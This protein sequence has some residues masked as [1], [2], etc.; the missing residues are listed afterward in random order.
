MV[1][2]STRHGGASAGTCQKRAGMAA[3]AG[4]RGN[5]HAGRLLRCKNPNER[6]AG[7]SLERDQWAVIGAR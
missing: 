6:G 4:T 7:L 3:Y 5:R 1:H 2:G